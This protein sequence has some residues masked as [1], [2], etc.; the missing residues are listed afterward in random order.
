MTK[1]M[2]YKRFTGKNGK[3]Y[4]VAEVVMDGTERDIQNGLVGQKVQEVFLPENKYDFF[5]PEHVGKELRFD[6]ELSGGRA[7]V[8][9]VSVK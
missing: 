6:Y 7:Y 1:L 5:K 9:D 3:A 8:V 2:G 4:C